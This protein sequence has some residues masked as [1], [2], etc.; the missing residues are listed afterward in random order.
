LELNKPLYAKRSFGQNFLVDRRYIDKIVTALELGP[1][2]QVIEI[3]AG[4][5]ALTEQLVAKAGHTFAIELDRDLIPLLR[6]KFSGRRNF[7]LIETNVLDFDFLDFGSK[8]PRKFIL[9]ANL[10]YYISTAVLQHLVA[11]RSAFSQ[12]VLMFQREVVDRILAKPGDAERGFL[13]VL[14]EAFLTVERLFDVPPTAFRP[15]P[16][17][18][19]SV[20]RLRPRPKQLIM[21]GSEQKFHDL[22]S[23]AFRHKRKTILNNFRSAPDQIVSRG[24]GRLLSESRIDPS[25]RAESLSIDEWVRLLDAFR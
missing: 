4:R 5:G 6:D 22:I 11:G 23:I 9:V 14:V 7:T 10:P 21:K 3:G 12:M 15:A 19:S 2:D 25:R 17:V 24:A 18:W 20:I 8:A 1:D 16:K 13:T